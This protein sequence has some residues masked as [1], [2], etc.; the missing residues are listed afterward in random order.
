M[1]NIKHHVI[2]VTVN[3]FKLA[4]KI[5]NDISILYKKNMEVKNAHELISPITPSLIN[6]FYSFFIAP[7]GSKEGY[8]LSEDGDNI[9][10]KIVTHLKSYKGDGF[11][12]PVNFVEIFYGDDKLKPEILNYL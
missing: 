8:D 11:S 3:D 4:E 1:R 6:N 9:R 12:V 7:D 2:I 10:E 5:K